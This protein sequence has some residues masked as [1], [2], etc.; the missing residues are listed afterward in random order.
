MAVMTIAVDAPI[1]KKKKKKKNT[2]LSTQKLREITAF[3]LKITLITKGNNNK[4]QKR[5][6]TKADFQIFKTLL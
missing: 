6:S 1:T 5:A 2:Q 3:F 4:K